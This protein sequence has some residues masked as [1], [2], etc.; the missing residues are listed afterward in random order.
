MIVN[1]SVGHEAVLLPPE[2]EE[3]GHIGRVRVGVHD[4][5]SLMAHDPFGAHAVFVARV[6]VA[7][8]RE[9]VAAGGVAS[10]RSAVDH[11]ARGGA[12]GVFVVEEGRGGGRLV[13]VG[14]PDVVDCGEE[15]AFSLLEGGCF[16]SG[17]FEFG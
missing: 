14:R 11:G 1:L 13:V 4:G 6:S 15:A 2:F 8:V 7:L 16:G 9:D 12:E 17:E 10:V 3:E 5:Q